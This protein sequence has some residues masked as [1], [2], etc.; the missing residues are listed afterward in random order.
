[1]AHHLEFNIQDLN[2]TGFEFTEKIDPVYENKTF[3]L[4][5]LYYD[6]NKWDIRPDA[7]VVLDDV[8]EIMVDNPTL[9]I[10]LSS[11]TDSRGSDRYNQQLSQKRAESAVA[12]IVSKGIDS[13][14]IVA[15]GYG[16]SRLVNQ[17][18]NGVK[19]SEEE[20]QLNRRTEIE[21]TD[22]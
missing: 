7:A 4:E 8:Y 14:R 10:E 17:C 2:S 22:Y 5:G 21:V 9:K 19:C 13:N 15:R 18:G 11:H 6:L 16:E 3:V 12:Y 1:M 20:H